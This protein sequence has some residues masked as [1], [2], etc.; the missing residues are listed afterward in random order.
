MQA[1]GRNLP[2][3]S[4]EIP[5]AHPVPLVQRSTCSSLSQADGVIK[6]FAFR[7]PRRTVTCVQLCEEA[8]MHLVLEK[9]Q[10]QKTR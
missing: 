4:Y 5:I 1:M 2:E 9:P 6:K 10:L 3:T 8:S 7:Y